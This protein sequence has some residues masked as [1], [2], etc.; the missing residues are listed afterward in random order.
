MHIENRQ[1]ISRN[2]PSTECWR[3]DLHATLHLNAITYTEQQYHCTKCYS[4]YNVTSV[5]KTHNLILFSTGK[6]WE[7]HKHTTWPTAPCLWSLQLWLVSGWR[8][9]KLQIS[10]PYWSKARTLP[11]YLPT[12]PWAIKKRATLFSIITPAFLDQFLYFLYRWKQEGILYNLL[13]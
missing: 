9:K 2:E 10:T 5:K 3:C 6:T 11:F 7:V 1:M 13:I 4:F 12:T 8:L